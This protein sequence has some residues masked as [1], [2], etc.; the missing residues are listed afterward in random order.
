MTPTESVYKVMFQVG[1]DALQH[2]LLEASIYAKDILA[3]LL[4]SPTHHRLSY[5]W[6][7]V[8]LANND[9]RTRS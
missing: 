4:S 2:K 3:I 9:Y 8:G 1:Q 7:C 5:L 6:N